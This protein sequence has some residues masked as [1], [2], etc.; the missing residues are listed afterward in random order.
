MLCARVRLFSCAV[1]SSVIVV[2]CLSLPSYT[3]C[4]L[5]CDNC[6]L[7][8]LRLTRRTTEVESETEGVGEG[9]SGTKWRGA[10]VQTLAS[11]ARRAVG[12]RN[13]QPARPRL[14]MVSGRKV[15]TVWEQMYR[16]KAKESQLERRGV[17]P[18]SSII[19]H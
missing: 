8:D 11:S 4:Q 17:Y 6:S 9:E 12:C 15:K 19:H 3:A 2:I 5:G 1:V 16:V 13:C 7:C 10:K 18:G 14:Q